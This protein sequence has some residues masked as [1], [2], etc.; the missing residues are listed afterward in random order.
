MEKINIVKMCQAVLSIALV[1]TFIRLMIATKN[2]ERKD[3]LYGLIATAL[4][5]FIISK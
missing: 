1:T 4:S 5:L 2:K 3:L